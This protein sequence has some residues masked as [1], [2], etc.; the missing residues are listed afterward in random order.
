MTVDV[1]APELVALLLGSVRAAAWLLV[2]P[3]F[4]GRA[5]PAS[6]RVVIALGLALPFVD[7]LAPAVVD[8]STPQLLSA[9]LLQVL[10]GT[11]LGFLTYLMFAAVQAAGDMIDFFGGFT[12][13]SAYD[14]ISM[15]TSSVFGRVHT[16]LATTLLFATDAHLVVVDGFL[17]TYEVLPLDR[18]LDVTLL[19]AAVVS[20][21]GAFFLAAVQIAAPLIAVLFL[22][23]IGLG[24]VTKVSPELNAFSLGFPVKILVTILLVGLTFPMLPQTVRN[25]VEDAYRLTGAVVG[26]S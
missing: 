23:D 5:I 6:A 11:A 13:S 19:G 14:P 3:P 1:P 21:L 9:V 22:A 12:I 8:L 24:L 18:G 7:R 2:A 10:T 15:S 16:L 4:A 25:L 17:R 26:G 20:G